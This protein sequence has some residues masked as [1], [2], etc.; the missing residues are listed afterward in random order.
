VT[1][2]KKKIKKSFINRISKFSGNRLHV[3]VPKKERKNFTPG[4][5]V[6]VEKIE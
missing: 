1:K 6:R 2:R 5:T 4:D 3:E